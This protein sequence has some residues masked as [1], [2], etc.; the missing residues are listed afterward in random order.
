MKEA[1]SNFCRNKFH[2]SRKAFRSFWSLFL[3]AYGGNIFIL[4]ECSR[5]CFPKLREKAF[6]AFGGKSRN[7]WIEIISFW[8]KLKQSSGRSSTK[9]L[10]K[11]TFISFWRKIFQASGGSF[12]KPL[13]KT[14]RSFWRKLFQVSRG[15]IFKLLKESSQAFVRSFSMLQKESIS[16]LLEESFTSF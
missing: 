16:K 4:L 12:S 8:R 10:E 14:F 1:F 7:L 9:L 13:R 5:E 3:K 11:K 6:A 15:S 2:T